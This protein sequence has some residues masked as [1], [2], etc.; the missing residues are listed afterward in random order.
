MKIGM[1]GL[2]E[3]DVFVREGFEGAS[4]IEA[5][6]EKLTTGDVFWIMV[7]TALIEQPKEMFIRR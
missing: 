1:I 2:G 4:S 6:A 7:P 5:L 3:T